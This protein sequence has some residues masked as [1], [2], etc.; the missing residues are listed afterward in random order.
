[1][2]PLASCSINAAAAPHMRAVA[3]IVRHDLRR[4]DRRRDD[5]ARSVGAIEERR[6]RRTVRARPAGKRRT[7]DA[8]G[9]LH[10]NNN[11]SAAD[12][13]ARRTRHARPAASFD[14]R[15]PI[16]HARGAHGSH[17]RYAPDTELARTEYPSDATTSARYRAAFRNILSTAIPRSCAK[18]S[19]SP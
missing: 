1:M 12:A 10:R 9:A 17:R 8:H 6:L 3:L 19:T 2:L 4:G 14:R 18:A 15:A 16:R 11:I 5:W 7:E 13:A